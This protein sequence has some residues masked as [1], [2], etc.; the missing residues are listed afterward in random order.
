MSAAAVLVAAL[1]GDFHVSVVF[2]LF[3]EHHR[4]R[5]RSEHE[6]GENLL[7]R[8]RI[9][10]VMGE[11]RFFIDDIVTNEGPRAWPHMMLYHVNVGFPVVD[12]GARLIAPS[13]KVMP[14][15]ELAA[16][17]LDQHDRFISRPIAR[18]GRSPPSPT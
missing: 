5:T 2:A 4:L 12:A 1:G 18:A 3:K 15:T 11:S 17:E 6:H 13:R 16:K 8:R 7:L 10:A 14:R 9:S